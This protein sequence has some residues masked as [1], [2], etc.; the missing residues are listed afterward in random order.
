MIPSLTEAAQSTCALD[1]SSRSFWVKPILVISRT[2]LKFD[3]YRPDTLRWA[4][5]GI[6]SVERGAGKRCTPDTTGCAA[7]GGQFSVEEVANAG[8]ALGSAIGP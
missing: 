7:T 4:F 5:F 3:D 6:S 1:H 2:T 8:W